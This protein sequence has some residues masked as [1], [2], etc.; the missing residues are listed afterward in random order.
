MLL[1]Y[2]LTRTQ[3]HERKGPM[4][5]TESRQAQERA[6]LDLFG[7]LSAGRPRASTPRAV[8]DNRPSLSLPIPRPLTRVEVER[9]AELD[10]MLALR[11]A[12]RR[13]Q[14]AERDP[15]NE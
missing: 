3:E 2:G 4:R 6:Q 9:A 13:Q 10:R 8:N 15:G 7:L 5:T 12:L 11:S 1:R 14:V